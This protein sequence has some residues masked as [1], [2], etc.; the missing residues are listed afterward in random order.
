MNNV[1][2]PANTPEA[3]GKRVAILRG[4][5]RLSR[6]AFSEQYLIAARTLQNW[7]DAL[8][9]GISKGG[10]RKIVAAIKPDGIHCT[11]E[12]LMFGIGEGPKVIEPVSNSALEDS[13]PLS[14]DEQDKF[15]ADELLLFRHHHK[16]VIDFVVADNGMEPRFV[17]GDYVAGI[18]RAKEAIDSIVGLDCIV[19]TLD[20]EVLLRT[21]KKGNAAGYYTLICSNSHTTIAKPILYDVVLLYAAPVIWTRRKD[22]QG[23]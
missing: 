15:I 3:R 21:V 12:W 2:D 4:M 20:G 14:A 13:P 10:A 6:R 7:E 8:S 23:K 22:P 16:G 11:Y 1:N 5:T 18:R 17:V 19:Q 9:G